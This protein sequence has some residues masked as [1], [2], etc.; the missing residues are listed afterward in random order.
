MLEK[1]KQDYKTHRPVF[2]MIL[3]FVAFFIGTE[4]QT[5]NRQA[6]IERSE[7]ATKEREYENSLLGCERGNILREHVFTTIKIASE[8]AVNRRQA[9]KNII[10]EM[11]SAPTADPKTGRLDCRDPSITFKPEAIR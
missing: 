2:I 7:K 6:A 5:Q 8:S 4:I 11:Q 10:K 9:Y 1:I 3:V